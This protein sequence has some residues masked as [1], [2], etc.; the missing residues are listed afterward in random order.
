M[1][2]TLIFFIF[3]PMRLLLFLA[4]FSS[5]AGLVVGQS[6]APRI[7]YF[8]A[9]GRP[10]ST[11]EF[12]DLRMANP[13]ARDETV[14]DKRADGVV[15]F[16]LRPV[17][18]EGTPAPAVNFTTIDGKF[19]SPAELRGK[20]VVLNLWFIG[21]PACLGQEPGLN[22]LKNKFAGT[23]AVFIAATEDS[24]KDVAAY[25]RKNPFGYLQAA[26]AKAS[27]APFGP[28]IFPRNIVI[29]RDGRIVY[30]RSV[31]RSWEKFERVIREELAK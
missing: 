7:L 19:I 9:S 28:T 14:V 21:C 3:E 10:V 13:S 11:E 6:G 1:R 29:G 8:D 23:D 2:F 18:Q 31:I 22:A 12:V 4:M 20:V 26:D 16:R 27:M 5:A 15:E 30:W 17:P 25:L 24:A